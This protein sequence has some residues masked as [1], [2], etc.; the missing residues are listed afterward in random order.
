VGVKVLIVDD[1]AFMRMRLTNILTEYGYNV[2]GYGQ[3]GLEA[4]SGYVKYK[5]DI[6]LM[7][8]T[9]PE[10]NGIDALRKIKELDSHSVVI[11]CSAMGQQS[12]MKEAMVAGARDFIV[13]PFQ[14]DNVNQVL[15]KAVNNTE[16]LQAEALAV[17]NNYFGESVTCTGL[18]T[19]IDIAA[20]VKNYKGEFDELIIASDTLKQFE[21]VFLC[22]M[23]L[24][25]LKKEINFKNIVVNRLG[26]EG[27]YNILI[28][29]KQ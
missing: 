8:I 15:K 22:G 6:V 3:N 5:P 4:I 28:K 20:A 1:N 21:D 14:P 7:D 19:G 10:L 26:G 23:T 12:M 24:N 2:V 17:K 18:L 11:M 13:K 25:K 27:L 9:M 16:N 29:E